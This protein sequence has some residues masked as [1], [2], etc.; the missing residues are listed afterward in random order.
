[1]S[2][3]TYCEGTGTCSSTLT[4]HNN[5]G[6]CGNACSGPLECRSGAC[7]C[8]SGTYCPDTDTCVSTGIDEENCGRC[9]NVC[10]A[11]T[12]CASGTCQCDVFGLS[13]CGS[14]C[15]DRQTDDANC[16]RCGTVCTSGRY[17]ATGRCICPAPTPGVPVRVTSATDR[18]ERDVRLAASDTR[19][20][21]VWLEELRIGTTTTYT[22]KLALLDETGARVGPEVVLAGPTTSRL[23]SADIVWTG[24]EFGAVWTDSTAG[25]GIWLQRFDPSGA[26]LGLAVRVF[27]GSVGYVQIA[28]A[29]GSGYGI[30]FYASAGFADHDR[31]QRL[32]VDGSSPSL[33][34]AL[35]ALAGDSEPRTMDIAGAP[36]GRFG[37]LYHRQYLQSIAADGSLA[38]GP[39][40][41]MVGD[42]L[43]DARIAYDGRRW[44]VVG[45]NILGA[46]L[47]WRILL[48]RSDAVTSPLV[49][50]SMTSGP[51][52]RHPSIAYSG[53]IASVVFVRGY[54]PESGQLWHARVSTTATPEVI[55][56][57]V[58][59]TTDA[60]APADDDEPP[61]VAALG[62]TR[63]VVAWTDE[64][65]T[66]LDLYALGLTMESCD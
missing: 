62:P 24:T 59:I 30:A 13:L 39:R 5:C 40:N 43:S 48:V 23:A 64:R 66:Q 9:G 18:S 45:T 32:G 52:A 31:F 63:A 27:A 16:G 8:P 61:T 14:E 65:D 7:R 41:L 58:A 19:V 28:W 37:I 47:S 20:A 15:V 6:V 42:V 60:A 1:V 35:A 33:P 54:G 56:N 38:G 21:A 11:E 57:A 50:F 51:H 3:E 55:G 44:I 26:P 36:D 4:D 22:R 29:P 12:S 46:P 2:G 49:V 10:P 53:S 34:V 25:G 17:C